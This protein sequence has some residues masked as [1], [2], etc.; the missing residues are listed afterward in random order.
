MVETDAILFQASN[1]LKNISTMNDRNVLTYATT[2]TIDGKG[3]RYILETLELLMCRIK[4]INAGQCI[5]YTS[6]E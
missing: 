1:I 6:L 4:V 3:F 2:F 5:I